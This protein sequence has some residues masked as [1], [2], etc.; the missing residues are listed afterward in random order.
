MCLAVSCL[1]RF[2]QMC[3]HMSEQ[4]C[5]SLSVDVRGCWDSILMYTCISTCWQHSWRCMNVN[6]RWD[7]LHAPTCSL[8]TALCPFSSNMNLNPFFFIC[9]DAALLPLREICWKTSLLP[10]EWVWG[11]GSPIS[12]TLKP[13][14]EITL[15]AASH[16]SLNPSRLAGFFFFSSLLPCWKYS[17]D[18][19]EIQYN[20]LLVFHLFWQTARCLRGFYSLNREFD[21]VR[22]LLYDPDLFFMIELTNWSL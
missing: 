2:C 6:H 3:S 12:L 20:D 17:S 4:R 19:S 15:I 7:V 1:F 14:V 8:F 5:F 22:H 11:L 16:D 9:A 18:S 21:K 10:W 13:R